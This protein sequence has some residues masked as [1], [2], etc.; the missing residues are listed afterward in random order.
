M[1]FDLVVIIDC[2]G[3]AG[4]NGDSFSGDAEQGEEV[5][6]FLVFLTPFRSLRFLFKDAQH[7][8]SLYCL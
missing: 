1:N 3:I 4:R 8:L 2:G 5:P 6:L 7:S